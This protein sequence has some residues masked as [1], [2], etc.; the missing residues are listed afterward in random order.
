MTTP[1]RPWDSA[2]RPPGGEVM[3]PKLE[4]IGDP[5]SNGAPPGAVPTQEP[6]RAGDG[7]SAELHDLLNALQA[8]RVGDFSARLPAS[9]VGLMGKIADTF[10]EIVAANERMARQLERVGHVVGREGKTR[11][12]EEH[13][14]EL[15][16]LR[17]LV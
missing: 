11:R 14:S 3:Q 7:S 16:S 12:S 13:T 1:L 6:G 8:M 5:K 15:Q 9:Q 10:N 17:H 2:V 4:P